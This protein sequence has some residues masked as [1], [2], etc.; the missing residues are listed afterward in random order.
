MKTKAAAVMKLKV[1]PKCDHEWKKFKQT[2]I[3]TRTDLDLKLGHDYI[4]GKAY[5]I[6]KGCTKCKEKR[7]ID[8]VKE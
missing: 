8:Y 2:I 4:G 3:P 5:F 6:V 7:V 1:P